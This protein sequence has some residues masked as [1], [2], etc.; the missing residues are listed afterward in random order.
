MVAGLE[1]AE[2]CVQ[3][4]LIASGAGSTVPGVPLTAPVP[5]ASAPARSRRPGRDLRG[6]SGL[7]G[8]LSARE[9]T[10]YATEPGSTTTF[11]GPPHHGHHGHNGHTGTT[12]PG[13]RAWDRPPSRRAR[14]G[15]GSLWVTPRQTLVAGADVG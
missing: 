13:K 6:G 15:H 8:V 5:A 3:D 11:S 1:A 2:G 10:G 9:C 4:I 12:G 14:C 7:G